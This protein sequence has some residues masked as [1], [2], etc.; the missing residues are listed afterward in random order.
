MMVKRMMMSVK[1]SALRR[2]KKFFKRMR[3]DFWK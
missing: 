3:S 2:M 1:R